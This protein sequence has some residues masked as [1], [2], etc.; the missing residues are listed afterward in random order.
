MYAAGKGLEVYA[1]DQSSEGRKKA[2]QLAARENV[3][4]QYEVGDFFQLNLVNL[5]YDAV[6]L[7]YAHFPPPLLSRVHTKLATLLKPGG[8]LILEGFSLGNLAYRAVNPGIGGP[9]TPEM[10]FTVPGI[11]KDF[12]LLE[13]VFLREEEVQ[14]NEGKFHNGTGKVI[15]F[16]G[17]Y[18]R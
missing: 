15:R 17:R 14:L 16:I 9:P 10:L 1:F 12:E 18:P 8:I 7:I 11:R 2:L 6:A 4:I 5:R 13:E 3:T